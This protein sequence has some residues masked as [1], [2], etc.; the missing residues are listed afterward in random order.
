MLPQLVFT[1]LHSTARAIYIY[2]AIILNEQ[3][4]SSKLGLQRIWF[5]P[6]S[7]KIKVYRCFQL[8]KYQ[9]REK[10]EFMK[11]EIKFYDELKAEWAAIDEDTVKDLWMRKAILCPNSWGNF[12]C[13]IM[14]T[15]LEKLHNLFKVHR[16][17]YPIFCRN[18]FNPFIDG[19]N[20]LDRRYPPVLETDW[21]VSVLG[22]YWS[23][24]SM[25]F[26]PEDSI[27]GRKSHCGTSW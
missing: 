25:L 9:S 16:M 6:S 11:G 2:S 27:H 18:N 14:Q 7:H 5:C 19:E 22:C 24:P 17:Q 13:E 3:F 1:M 15:C 23:T 10:F 12:D 26:I 21:F 8:S 20:C 4:G